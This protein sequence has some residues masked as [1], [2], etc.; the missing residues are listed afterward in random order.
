[1]KFIPLQAMKIYRVF[2]KVSALFITLLIL[3]CS[4]SYAAQSGYLEYNSVLFDYSK[5]NAAAIQKEA[6]E[7]F[8]KF[9]TSSDELFKEQYLNAAMS[10]YYLLTKIDYSQITPYIQLAR[11]YDE[12][13][14]N[15]LAKEYFYKASN[16]DVNNPYANFY[17]GEFYF[18]RNDYKRALR[19]YNIAYN[20]GLNNRYDLNLRLATIYEK[21]ADLVNAKKFYEVSY[22]MNPNNVELR[23][24]IQSL[25]E[26]NYDKSE[27]Y[28]FIRE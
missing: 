27:Y 11:I 24:K 13:N 3:S 9:I 8:E 6:D 20:N 28:H 18:K 23:Q 16:L 4:H 26:L 2:N 7:Y 10:K 5:L 17:F 12:K 25:N 19:Y 22:S 15:R 14:N 21:F 1:M